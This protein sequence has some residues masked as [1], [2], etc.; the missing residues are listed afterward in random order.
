MKSHLL[1]TFR[2]TFLF[3][4]VTMFTLPAFAAPG[5]CYCFSRK[6]VAITL[7]DDPSLLRCEVDV[8]RENGSQTLVAKLWV[9]DGPFIMLEPDFW[10]RATIEPGAVSEGPEDPSLPPLDSGRFS[11]CGRSGILFGEAES[12][13]AG[14][15]Q[16]CHRIIESVC[17]D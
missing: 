15:A 14:N 7:P 13:T 4:A 3:A 9:D 1:N 8:A 2:A 17:R 10:A 6:D 16:S 12:Y 11:Y 5:G